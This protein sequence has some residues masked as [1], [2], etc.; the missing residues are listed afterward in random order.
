MKAKP[1]SILISG[2]GIAGPTLAYVLRLAANPIVTRWI[3]RRFLA[4]N[5]ELADYSTARLEPAG[6]LH[7]VA[8]P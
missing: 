6:F 4:D 7:R 5:F 2:A 8:C 3:M 1:V